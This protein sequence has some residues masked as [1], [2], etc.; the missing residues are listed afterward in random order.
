MPAP[1]R[2][3]TLRAQWLGQTLKA[4]R[5]RSHLRLKDSAEYLQRDVSMVSRFESGIYPIRRGDVYALIDLYGIEDRK[6]RE[7]LLQLSD[8]VWQT[9]WWEKHT[10][11]V[12]ASTIDYVWLEDRSEQLR[13]YGAMTVVGLLQTSEY[14]EA[15]IRAADPDAASSQISRWVQL[16]LRRQ[17]LLDRAEGYRLEVVL[18]EAAL[19]R[20]VGGPEI[21]CRQLEHLLDKSPNHGIEVRVLPF[22]AGAH[23]SPDGSFTLLKMPEPFPEVAYVESPAGAIYAESSEAERLARRYDRLKQS[24]LNPEES[25]ALITRLAEETS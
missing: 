15:L 4:M 10:E 1:S 9:G 5:E 2:K 17:E 23:S 18:D 19:R 11:D 22:S 8:E 16:R 25:A 7:L 6:Q 20:P 3:P 24:S 14:A 12:S 13:I 21:M